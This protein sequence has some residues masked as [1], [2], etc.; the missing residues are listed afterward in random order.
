M[1]QCLIGD[2]SDNYTGCPGVGKVGAEKLLKDYRHDPVAMWGIVVQRYEK[3][4]LSE[5]EALIQA[6]VSRICRASDYNFTTQSPI[7]WRKPL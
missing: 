3:A 1:M 6:Q 5:D 2:S 4:G 7:L